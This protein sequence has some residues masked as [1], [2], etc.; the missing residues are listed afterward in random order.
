M[1]NKLTLKTKHVHSYYA[2]SNFR[3]ASN[4]LP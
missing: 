4:A 2:Y 3:Y 1:T